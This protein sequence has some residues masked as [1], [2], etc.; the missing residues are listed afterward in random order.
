MERSNLKITVTEGKSI[1]AVDLGGSSDPYVSIKC[2]GLKYETEVIKKCLSPQWYQSFDLGLVSNETELQFNLYD[3]D[4]IGKHKKLGTVDMTAGALK[5]LVI[6]GQNDKWLDFNKN[7][8]VNI[9]FEFNPHPKGLSPNQNNQNVV[10]D[11]NINSVVSPVQIINDVIVP[12]PQAVY[13]PPLYVATLPSQTRAEFVVPDE[14][15]FKKYF[16]TIEPINSTLILHVSEP[17]ILVRSLDVVLKGK[18]HVNGKK[19]KEIITDSRNLLHGF[20]KGK[21]RLERGKHIFP[22]VFWVPQDANSSM[23]VQNTYLV[24]YTLTFNADIVN[25]PDISIAKVINIVNMADTIHKLGTVEINHSAKKSPLTGGNIELS[26]RAPK[27][28]YFPGEDIEL[29]VT[30]NNESKK[31]IKKIDF[32]LLRWVTEG[33]KDPQNNTHALQFLNT[34]KHFFPKIR[35]NTKTTKS[36]VIE[37]PTNLV[38]STH[39]PKVMKIEYGLEVTLDIPK[40]IDIR[41]KVPITIQLPDPKREQLPTPLNEVSTIPRYIKDWSVRHV[42]SWLRFR[43]NCPSVVNDPEF[44]MYNLSGEEIITLSEPVL[45]NVLKGAGPR[46]DEILTAVKIEVDKIMVVRNLLKDHQLPHLIDL[47]EEE[48]ITSDIIGELTQVDLREMGIK[49]GDQKRLLKLI[50]NIAPPT[51]PKV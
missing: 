21:T 43:M 32:Q 8:F 16:I 1:K 20:T 25:L 26:V 40:M 42:H 37:L 33:N 48:L 10:V 35:Q 13:F 11:S 23:E 47:F 5:A 7:G 12:L 4:R 36:M 34:S 9:K 17:F 29:E 27:S 31:K 24:D 41:L 38:H 51:L 49:I 15:Y 22:F 19:H 28:N 39:Q 50:T 14:I 45:R 44:Y 18:I 46:I 2:N 3:W 6:N 30:V